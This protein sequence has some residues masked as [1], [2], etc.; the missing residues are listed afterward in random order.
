MDCAQLDEAKHGDLR[1]LLGAAA[2]TTREVLRPQ[3][4]EQVHQL[5]PSHID[6]MQKLFQLD[7]RSLANLQSAEI[8]LE[9]SKCRLLCSNC[10]AE[11]HNPDAMLAPETA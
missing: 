2:R 4:Q 1:N 9:A 8:L 7:I 6:P 10:H 11:H 3:V 5:S